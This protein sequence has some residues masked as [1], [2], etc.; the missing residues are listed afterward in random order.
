MN[1]HERHFQTAAAQTT[2]SPGADAVGV[3]VE[4]AFLGSLLLAE[5]GHVT[6][7]LAESIVPD[8]FVADVH[9]IIFEAIQTLAKRDQPPT[10][11]LLVPLLEGIRAA[12]DMTAAAYL[13][14]LLSV[15]AAPGHAKGYAKAIKL[16]SARRQIK[17]AADVALAASNSQ[18]EDV[19]Q[20]IG[21]IMGCLDSASAALRDRR[22]SVSDFGQAASSVISVLRRGQPEIIKTGL[23]PMDKVLAGWHRKEL[24]IIAARPGM[25]KSAFLFSA[26][27]SAA[28]VKTSSLIFSME[29]P[30]DMVT[31]RM[32]SDAVWNRETPIPYERYAHRDLP[33]HEID[34]LEGVAKK[35]A[36]LPMTIDDQVGLTVSEIRTRTK[37]HMDKLDNAGHRLD[38]VVIDHL[39][40]IRASD[41][42][43]GNKVH[44]TGEKTN[45][46]AEMAK[47]LDV[48][49]VCAHQLNRGPE[50]RDNKRP[51]LADLRDTGDVEQ[52][53]ET[54]ILLFR[55]AYYLQQRGGDHAHDDHDDGAK[56]S[57][58][59]MTEE[60]RVALLEEVKNELE[61]IVAK[62]RNGPCTTVDLYIDVGSNVVRGK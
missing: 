37:R 13:G 20:Q 52:D 40:K 6:A 42:Y 46:L 8:D 59:K 10:T 27:L 53:A 55:Q 57:K 44:E 51:T 35:N 1:R 48:A 25:G 29:M 21:D 12:P 4:Q 26:F 18:N 24:S 45:A 43:A 31:K 22:P 23:P 14:R 2:Q 50:N 62:N 9:R 38:C 61:A 32:L 33:S 47:E 15:A 19:L 36:R 30:T 5:H 39:G 49:V 34:R 17:L 56:K 58:K 60:E 16:R 54:V 41:R 11:M 7:H 3:E 28:K